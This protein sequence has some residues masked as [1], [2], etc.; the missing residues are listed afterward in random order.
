MIPLKEFVHQRHSEV[1]DF[2]PDVYI[3]SDPKTNTKKKIRSRKKIRY[4]CLKSVPRIPVYPT[5]DTQMYNL[6][7]S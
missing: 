1:V 5:N 3:D 2:H 4:E 7:S 6:L